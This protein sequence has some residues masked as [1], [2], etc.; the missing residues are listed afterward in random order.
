MSR[1]V[2]IVN[3]T[4]IAESALLHDASVLIE[5]GKITRI[6]QSTVPPGVRQVD[7]EGNFISPG[8]IDLHIHGFG[9]YDATCCNVDSLVGMS[10]S[11]VAHGTTSFLPTLVSM[12]IDRTKAFLSSVRDSMPKSSGARILGANL[13]GPFLNPAKRGVHRE[14][15]LAAPSLESLNNMI[16][17]YEGIIRIL[18]LAPE[19][20][21]GLQLCRQIVELGMVAAIGH[22]NAT[23]AEANA[24]IKAGITHATHTFNGMRNIESR[25]M[26]AAGAVL[27]SDDVKAEIIADGL[28][29][30]PETTKLMVK[31]KGPRSLILVTDAVMPT[32]TSITRFDLAGVRAYVE[33]GGSFT[34]D[35]KLCGSTLTLE[36]AVKNLMK[37]NNLSLP[38]AVRMASLNP[39]EQMGIASR[40][41]SLVE[42]KDADVVILD[43][44]LNVLTTFV[45]GE[46]VYPTRSES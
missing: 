43:K 34:E 9:G 8:F 26:G 15:H 11:L 23:Y 22:T 25:E 28:H 4:V 6:S 37:W 36:R 5:S 19:L 33:K 24:G 3:G 41:G 7:A 32:G 12:P 38:D 1:S 29:V 18:T 10:R 13:E 16:G 21:G 40:T 39:A 30:S 17:G 14:E 35:G 2:A 45:N 46:Q 42:G 20:P 31:T 44:E 27:L